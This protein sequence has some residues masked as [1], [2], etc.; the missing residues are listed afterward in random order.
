MGRP[1]HDAEHLEEIKQHLWEIKVRRDNGEVVEIL[2]DTT[3][4]KPKSEDGTGKTY[5]VAK[6]H[7]LS[8]LPEDI[9]ANHNNVYDKCRM[10]VR[11]SKHIDDYHVYYEESLEDITPSDNNNVPNHINVEEALTYNPVPMCHGW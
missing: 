9:A 1:I 3:Y 7:L 8:T 11:K 2:P 6:Y 4:C 10:I 5:W